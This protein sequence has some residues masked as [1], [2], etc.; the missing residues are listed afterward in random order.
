MPTAIVNQPGGSTRTV[1]VTSGVYQVQFEDVAEEYKEKWTTGANEITRVVH[2][3][4]EDSDLFKQDCLGWCENN[5]GDLERHLPEQ[6]PFYPNMWCV[7][8][9]LV[10]GI[11]TPVIDEDEGFFDFWDL[12][13]EDIN[14]AV[15]LLTD[16][17][18][19]P[20]SGRAKFVLTYRRLPYAVL[21]DDDVDS[22]FDRF[23]ERRKSYAIENL[24]LPGTVFKFQDDNTSA[25]LEKLP[26][27]LPSNAL[28]YTWRSVPADGLLLPKVLDD[29][30]ES[31]LGAVN[32]AEFDGRYATGTLL[33][34]APEVEPIE[35]ANGGRGFDIHFKF[36]YRSQG[37]NSKWRP[38][39]IVSGT[40]KPA[41]F[42]PI[43]TADTAA[44]PPYPAVDFTTLF[45]LNEP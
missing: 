22:E 20:P 4:W 45:S 15:R 5:A 36:I 7:A 26:Y 39:R 30:I 28:I 24:P 13:P 43:V 16:P 14:P 37:W 6:H 11:G 2:C 21:S 33:C 34:D 41:G 32:N 12:G 27:R 31:C 44:N 38:G 19:P 3:A 8:A 17:D 40:F 29:A 42:Y 35:M 25:G 1:N 9:D 18:A 10:E 23:V